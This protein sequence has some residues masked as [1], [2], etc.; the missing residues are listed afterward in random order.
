MNTTQRNANH[1]MEQNSTQLYTTHKVANLYNAG[2]IDYYFTTSPSPLITS[3]SCGFTS[4]FCNA[5]G[6]IRA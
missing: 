4:A 1:E 3:T 6:L 2:Y 5:D